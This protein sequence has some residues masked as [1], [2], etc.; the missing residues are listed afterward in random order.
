MANNSEKPV[1]TASTPEALREEFN[2]EVPSEIASVIGNSD[3]IARSSTEYSSGLFRRCANEFGFHEMDQFKNGKLSEFGKFVAE[4]AKGKDVIDLGCGNYKGVS[5]FAKQFGARRYIGVDQEFNVIH[6]QSHLP[7]V[8]EEDLP[9]EFKIF[10]QDNFFGGANYVRTKGLGS[11]GI[12]HDKKSPAYFVND[13]ILG[14]LAKIPGLCGAVFVMGGIQ[15]SSRGRRL[16]SQERKTEKNYYDYL[17]GELARLA[18]DGDLVMTSGADYGLKECLKKSG[19]VEYPFP[20][21]LDNYSVFL[22]C[23]TNS[24]LCK[25]IRSKLEQLGLGSVE[26]DL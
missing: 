1:E 18:Q 15:L 17:S 11:V 3:F 2:R 8:G 10:K 22:K 16:T 4:M 9:D 14:F 19:F 20:N 25:T 13:D 24:T 23:D 6:N 12:G 21:F 26:S 7:Y 5:M